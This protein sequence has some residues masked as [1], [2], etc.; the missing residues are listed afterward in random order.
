[1]AL[2]D[3]F[4]SPER[5][6]TFPVG[7]YKLNM[8]LPDGPPLREFSKADYEALGAIDFV[9][10]KIY[11]APAVEFVGR[12]WKASLGAVHSKLYKIALFVET[13]DKTQAGEAAFA[14][15]TFCNNQLG[16][17]TQQQTGLFMWDTTDG[18]VILQTVPA[19]DG[20]AVNFFLTAS[21]VREFQRRV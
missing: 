4:K 20:F 6:P 14:A 2:W 10:G 11:H 1:M 9:G 12:Q 18:N 7:G 8:T 19:L 5:K 16:K 3:W 13:H 17:P 21:S 15:L